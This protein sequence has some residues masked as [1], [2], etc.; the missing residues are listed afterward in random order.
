MKHSAKIII[1]NNKVFEANDIH[2][3]H[4]IDTKENEIEKSATGG[5]FT[6]KTKTHIDLDLSK[7]HSLYIL[8]EYNGKTTEYHPFDESGAS[9]VFYKETVE[10]DGVYEYVFTLNFEQKPVEEKES[11]FTKIKNFFK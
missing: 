5:L 11:I 1:D 6:I 2:C 3:G 10:K 9:S 8:F 4:V 7:I